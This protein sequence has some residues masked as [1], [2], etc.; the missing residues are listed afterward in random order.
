MGLFSRSKKLVDALLV[1]VF[2]MGLPPVLELWKQ[3]Q[4]LATP[5]LGQ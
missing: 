1:R 3:R 4:R 2:K 5:L